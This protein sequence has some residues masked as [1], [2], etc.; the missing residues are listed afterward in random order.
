MLANDA[1]RFLG[2]ERITDANR[3][4]LRNCRSHRL[5]VNHFRSK[6]RQF[7][8]FVVRQ[9]IDYGSLGHTPRIGAEDAVHISPNGNFL[10]IQKIA[11]N[12]S[13]KVTAIAAKRGL[14]AVWLS[15]NE[16]GN[17]QCDVAFMGHKTLGIGARLVPANGRTEGG[18]FDLNDVAGIHPN[19]L[20][21]TIS[22]AGKVACKQLRRP[23][24]TKAWDEIANRQSG[25]PN[26][27]DGVEDTENVGTVAVDFFDIAIRLVRGAK[28][29][30]DVPVTL[31]DTIDSVV[32]VLLA[33]C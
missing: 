14:Q 1:A 27:L 18:P 33:L 13:G 31:T 32:K 10:R 11:E 17:D 25:G 24:L 12:G 8:G 2:C 6:V 20:A 7:H 16:T 29:K 5:R 3:N 30:R 15:R 28:L 9:R 21:R 26:E 23:Y 22:A 19:D 4:A